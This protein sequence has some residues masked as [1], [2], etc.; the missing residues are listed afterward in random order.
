MGYSFLGWNGGLDVVF[1][2]RGI[3]Q[4]KCTSHIT[5]IQ[6]FRHHVRPTVFF[7]LATDN[8]EHTG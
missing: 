1:V 7:C 5:A 8:L 4:N 3:M 6:E 2:E